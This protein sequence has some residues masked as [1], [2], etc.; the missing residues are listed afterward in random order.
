MAHSGESGPRYKYALI[1][2]TSTKEAS[3]IDKMPNKGKKELLSFIDSIPDDKLTGLRPPKPNYTIF[4]NV[5]LRLDN[6]GYTST[7][8]KKHNLQ[9]QINRGTT[10]STLKSA[11]KKSSQRGTS[12]AI[13]EV[14][15]DGSWGAK[16]IKD[17]LKASSKI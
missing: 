14:P 1:R 5:N 8:P 4:T 15:D 17:T 16:K 9:V 13:A 3:S 11:A 7:D 2:C 6:Q 12:V 10:I